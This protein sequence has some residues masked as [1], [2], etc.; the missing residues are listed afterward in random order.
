MTAPFSSCRIS[1]GYAAG[2]RA[3]YFKASSLAAINNES[4]FYFG[5]SLCTVHH[6]RAEIPSRICHQLQTQ[7]SA[8]NLK[9]LNAEC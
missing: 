9:K 4:L 1:G 2:G 6:R 8:C 5:F 3:F 7:P